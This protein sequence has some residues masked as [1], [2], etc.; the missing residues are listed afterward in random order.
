MLRLNEMN[1]DDISVMQQLKEKMTV[2]EAFGSKKR[3][4]TIP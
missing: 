3:D 2:Y 1:W 4:M